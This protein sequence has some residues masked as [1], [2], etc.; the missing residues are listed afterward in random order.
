MPDGLHPPSLVESILS[1]AFG[2]ASRSSES[3]AVHPARQVLQRCLRHFWCCPDIGSEGKHPS[4]GWCVLASSSISLL[5]S[6]LGL[7]A[8][9]YVSFVLAL[10]G[11]QKKGLILDDPVRAI[12]HGHVFG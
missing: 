1:A 5:A 7:S 11:L 2:Q 12:L 6:L 4:S 3:Q 8:V 9:F 10:A